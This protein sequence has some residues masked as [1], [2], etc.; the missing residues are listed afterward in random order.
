MSIYGGMKIQAIEDS[1][2]NYYKD[3]IK[4]K[5][6][7]KFKVGEKVI[8]KKVGEC[9]STY[10]SFAE[11][12][13]ATKYVNDNNPTPN[14]EGKVMGF[15]LHEDGNPI[16]YLVDTGEYEYLIGEGGLIIKE[17]KENQFK[18][19][20]KIRC[21]ENSSLLKQNGIYTVTELVP[22]DPAG[23]RIKEYCD[24][25]FFYEYR[26]ESVKNDYKVI[27]S[28]TIKDILEQSPC[29]SKGEVWD[30]MKEFEDRNLSPNLLIHSWEFFSSFTTLLEYKDWFIEKGF[31]EK[32]KKPFKSFN[33]KISSKEE[34]ESLWCML[35]VPTTFVEKANTGEYEYSDDCGNKLWNQIDEEMWRVKE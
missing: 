5:E 24:S 2:D 27:K 10:N 12:L 22:G 20:E 17:S 31:L 28:F 11:K 25:G 3:L 1:K 29:N 6:M 18:V 15:T 23:I 9:Y 16:V 21:I 4:E 13:N 32:I 8:I 26:F 35:N 19:G 7:N 34:L 14:L 30:L 33:L